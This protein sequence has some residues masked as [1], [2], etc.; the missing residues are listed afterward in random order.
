MAYA[1]SGRVKKYS[2]RIVSSNI[3]GMFNT[4]CFVPFSVL[5]FLGNHAE[6]VSKKDLQ[7]S[8]SIWKEG[9]PSQTIG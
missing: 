8:V 1:F 2:D 4:N 7:S 9:Y 5:P 3:L 6:M